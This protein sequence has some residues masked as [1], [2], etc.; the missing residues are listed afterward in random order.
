MLGVS[1]VPGEKKPSGPDDLA[2]SSVTRT[3]NALGSGSAKRAGLDHWTS[4]PCA[5][6]WARASRSEENGPWTGAPLGL[7]T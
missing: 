6:A 2:G 3:R 5:S 7:R 4:K 1:A